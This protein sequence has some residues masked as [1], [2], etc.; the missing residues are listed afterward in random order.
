MYSCTAVVVLNVVRVVLVASRSTAVDDFQHI[1]I[2]RNRNYATWV[3]P[4]R[5]IYYVNWLLRNRLQLI[6]FDS[7]PHIWTQV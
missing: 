5:V 2:R 7:T 6:K 3:H 1:K 4:I